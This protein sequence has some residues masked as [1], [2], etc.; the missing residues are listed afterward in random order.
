MLPKNKYDS[1]VLIS[2]NRT[3]S[4]FDSDTLYLLESF[5]RLYLDNMEFIHYFKNKV[6]IEKVFFYI[7]YDNNGY[8]TLEE[9][10]FFLI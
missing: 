1:M 4:Y 3:Q 6:D 8:I 9:V 10:G 5:F 2:K 7:D